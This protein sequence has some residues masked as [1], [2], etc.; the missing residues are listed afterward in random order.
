MAANLADDVFQDDDADDLNG[1]TH[2]GGG[3]DVHQEAGANEADVNKQKADREDF[4]EE[5]P[6][7]LLTARHATRT[8][9]QCLG[10]CLCAVRCSP[11]HDACPYAVFLSVPAWQLKLTIHPAARAH[12][13]THGRKYRR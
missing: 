6:K 13:N 2:Y 4:I 12:R 1:G 7:V 8:H 9:L 11:L 3:D 5:T 10:A